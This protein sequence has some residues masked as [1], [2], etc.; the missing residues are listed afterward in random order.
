MYLLPKILL[1]TTAL[2]LIFI[3]IGLGVGLG[4]F[5]GVARDESSTARDEFNI[6]IISKNAAIND[7][8]S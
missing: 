6:S 4:L 1:I 7:I 2:S 8:V 5:F 3:I